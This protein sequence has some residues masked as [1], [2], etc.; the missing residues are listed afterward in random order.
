MKAQLD[1]KALGGLGPPLHGADALSQNQEVQLAKLR[2]QT[3]THWLD[4][5]DDTGIARNEL[6]VCSPLADPLHFIY[7]FLTPL[8]IATNDDHC[9]IGLCEAHRDA[10]PDSTCSP[11][12]HGIL[13]EEIHC[14]LLSA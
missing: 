6:M 8:R 2:V 4:I 3:V 1:I 11:D 9:S 14:S 5:A 12:H 7:D 13:A 10:L